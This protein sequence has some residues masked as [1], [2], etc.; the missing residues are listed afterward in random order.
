MEEGSGVFVKREIGV[1][2][3]QLS[4]IQVGVCLIQGIFSSSA[5]IKSI[6][7]SAIPLSDS[8]WLLRAQISGAVLSVFDLRW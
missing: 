5:N 4:I 6:V 1:A 8:N 3:S 2:D 7:L